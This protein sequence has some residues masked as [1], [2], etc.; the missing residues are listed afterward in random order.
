MRPD[1]EKGVR[2]LPGETIMKKENN[3]ELSMWNPRSKLLCT[4]RNLLALTAAILVLPGGSAL[5]Y[6][7]YA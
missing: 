2:T 1:D 3:T 4:V 6:L 5:A 7:A